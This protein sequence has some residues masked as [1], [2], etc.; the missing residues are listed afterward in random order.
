VDKKQVPGGSDLPSG[1]LEQEA[2]Q[3]DLQ[4]A[5]DSNAIDVPI[6]ILP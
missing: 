2:G 5:D 4:T 3:V 1:E 6:L